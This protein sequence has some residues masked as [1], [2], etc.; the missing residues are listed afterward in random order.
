MRP[1]RIMVLGDSLASGMQDDYTWR[2]R[3]AEYLRRTG[4]PAEFVGP[5]TGTFSMYD[6]PVLLALVEG[7]PL[8]TGAEAVNPMTGTYREGPFH[9]G[10]CAQPGWTAHAAKASV[11]ER[12]AAERPDFLL[13]QLGFNDLAMVGPPEQ[14]LR[15]LA[16]IIAEARAAQPAVTIL[17]ANIAG[18]TAWGNEWFHQAVE[19][20][21][22]RLPAELAAHSSDRS[23]VAL[24]DVHSGF[25][26][27]D[28][29]Y[30]GIHPNPVGELAMA[31]AF[32]QALR[33][34]GIGS[35]PLLKPALRPRELPLVQ[36]EIIAARPQDSGVDVEWRRVPG[37]SAYRVGW[38]DLT[39]DQPRRQGPIPVLGDH[40]RPQGLTA[41][42]VYEFDVTAARG[43][44]L[45]PRS[46]PRRV[47]AGR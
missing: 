17:V 2:W 31:D 32:A 39:V 4:T 21:N 12:V 13:V 43:R 22:A 8:P 28:D 19:E 14:T 9:G 27:A 16:E 25:D 26:P 18:A 30:D 7:R 45:G 37:A 6:D 44:R 29:T 11:R 5:H 42:H 24:V 1:P 33:G 47:T 38:R 23:P 20:Y 15:D 3:L 10:H 46:K 41:G 40:W 35:G 36:P 34:F